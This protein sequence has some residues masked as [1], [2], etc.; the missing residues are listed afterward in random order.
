[1]K[2][3]DIVLLRLYYKWAFQHI[4][5]HR[6][7]EGFFF[8]LAT[9][10]QFK[11]SSQDPQLLARS[12]SLWNTQNHHSLLKTSCYPL[13][14]TKA[15]ILK[16]RETFVQIKASSY[17][18]CLPIFETLLFFFFTLEHSGSMRPPFSSRNSSDP[19]LEVAEASMFHTSSF[20][21]IVRVFSHIVLAPAF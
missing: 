16:L 21:L 3:L 20:P 13:F 11:F 9:E 8:G 14:K 19:A 7:L 12:P 4:S 18:S 10:A 15:H 6:N 17:G 1:M 5:C 2:N